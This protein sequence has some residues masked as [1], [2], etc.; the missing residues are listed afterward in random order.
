MVL[1]KKLLMKIFLILFVFFHVQGLG[2]A[3]EY[4]SFSADVTAGSASLAVGL[5]DLSI[6]YFEPASDCKISIIDSQ[7]FNVQT[8]KECT[9]EWYLD[10]ILVQ[11]DANVTSSRFI[12]DS[13][14]GNSTF[15]AQHRIKAVVFNAIGTD[16]KEWKCSVTR[17]VLRSGQKLELKDGYELT[18][19]LIDTVGNKALVNLSKDGEL[20]DQDIINVDKPNDRYYYNR[21]LEGNS[22]VIVYAHISN[23]FQGQ[24]E[25][26]AVFE[27]IEQYS[28][29]GT[30]SIDP[31]ILLKFE[32]TWDLGNCYSLKII[33]IATNGKSCLIS[34]DKDGIIVDR[35]ILADDNLYI[36]Q[37]VNKDTQDIKPILQIKVLDIFNSA[38][39]D[40]AQFSANYTLNP[41]VNTVDIDPF[42]LIG[43]GSLWTL[44]NGYIIHANEISSN[45]KAFITLKK[46]DITV[47]Q[48]IIDEYGA[49]TY[50]RLNP[51]NGTISQ[52][53]HVNS[54]KILEGE[55][56]DY[57]EFDPSYLINP[58]SDTLP[59]DQKRIVSVGETIELENGYS[60]SLLSISIQDKSA[61]IGLSKDGRTVDEHILKPGENY[62]YNQSVE[63]NDKIVISFLLDRVFS[64][65][66][67]KLMIIK[68]L[69]QNSYETPEEPVIR[70]ITRNTAIIR[71]LVYNGTSLDE[72]TGPLDFDRIE[73]NASNFAGFYYDVD[74]G[75][76]TESIWIYS[77]T[78]T[79]VNIIAPEGLT[80]T[81]RISPVDYKSRNLYGQYNI[82]GFL[83]EKCV[84]L[85]EK[86]PDKFSR[87]L[88]DSDEKLVLRLGQ[89]LELPEG[90]AL[91]AKQIDVEG[92]KVW[93]EFSKDG[94]FIEDE[95]LDL[96]NGTIVWTYEADDVADE[97]DVPVM[98]VAVTGLLQDQ[99]VGWVMIDG[100]WLTDVGNIIQVHSQ[101]Q[102][103][104]M[105]VV[106][107]GYNELYLANPRSIT[108][109]RG[110]SIEIMDNFSIRIAADDNL[111]FYIEKEDQTEDVCELRG[112]VAENV[113]TFQWSSAN[114]EGFYYEFD[115]GAGAEKLEL[116]EINGRI[117]LENKLVYNST[118][119]YIPFKHTPWGKYKAVGFITEKYFV[120]YPS[121]PFGTGSDAVD[122][123]SSGMLSKILVDESNT[124]SIYSGSSLFLEQGYRL[125]IHVDDDTCMALVI[126]AKDGNEIDTAVIT[127]NSTY[128]YKEDLGN[129]QNVPLIAVSFG[130]IINGI[131]PYASVNGVFQVSEDYLVLEQGITIGMMEI[132]GSS[133]SI[134]MSNKYPVSLTKG[135]SFPFMGDVCFKVADSSSLRFYP[136]VNTRAPMSPSLDIM[137]FSPADINIQSAEDEQQTFEVST[138]EICDFLWLINGVEAQAH[139]SCRSASYSITPAS[140]GFYNITVLAVGSGE[141][142]RQ[143]WDMRVVSSVYDGGKPSASSGGGGGGGT[144]SGEKYENIQVKEVKQQNVNRDSVV[145]YEFK[146]EKNA[147][148]SIE[149]TALKNSGT[150]SATIE[151]LKGKSSFAISDAPGK[152]YQNMNIWVGKTGFATPENIRNATL[153]Y[154][155]DRSWIE[156]NGVDESSIRMYRFHNNEWSSLP[157]QKVG[158]DSR[159]VYFESETLG[160]S[161]FSIAAYAS[162][163]LTDKDYQVSLESEPLYSTEDAFKDTEVVADTHKRT[164]GLGFM[165]SLVIM[166]CAVLVMRKRS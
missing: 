64:A 78:T 1:F 129:F 46:D 142:V 151:I 82:I 68:D 87:L 29:L 23:V 117:I 59:L 164:P 20:V 98:K 73:I 121:N 10:N 94:E 12:F 86:T 43:S 105:E 152:I 89:P 61:L 9:V 31:D 96:S 166:V 126:L 158:E 50:S 165:F 159:Y 2:S 51:V 144:A 160:F 47:D 24:V 21:T 62:Y 153:S 41:D 6:I 57:I 54:S 32:D 27:R 100:L 104:K 67:N 74:T 156:E 140:A 77:E 128:I 145:V 4:S 13:F 123:L 118:P 66:A 38:D 114:F 17:K 44:S 37:R 125:D 103:G 28:D 22:E 70:P 91:E 109:K 8:N 11:S 99:A 136:F 81:T 63:G 84:P 40:Y 92:D 48:A 33:D 141:T 90:Y 18:L 149:F 162:E 25:S 146:G 14:I 119:E 45:Q 65:E 80:Y 79:S 138:N 130:P 111:R 120:G 72:I 155:I 113:A 143:T 106:C 5:T 69:V 148:G 52:I 135:A 42:T 58:D 95:I 132:T 157:T 107:I 137:T 15:P 85:G 49:Y 112:E 163:E 150:V 131:E 34:L 75:I 102:F 97:D 16:E 134:I 36:Y 88:L 122:I 110:S 147:I 108:L 60:L 116:K 71:G 26:V 101:S 3:V 127:E 30:L 76:S 39:E 139:N 35:R 83:G 115:E 56:G 124:R 93:M 53:L 7:E 161:P 154:R 55:H 133:G 19:S